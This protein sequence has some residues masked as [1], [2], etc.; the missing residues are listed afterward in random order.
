M[1]I[2]II[3][4]LMFQGVYLFS[5]S[6]RKGL[7]LS[8]SINQALN[9]NPELKIVRLQT[10]K[11]ELDILQEF[12]DIKDTDLKRKRKGKSLLELE[13]KEKDIIDTVTYNVTERYYNTIISFKELKLAEEDLKITRDY[14]Y[15]TKKNFNDGKTDESNLEEVKELYKSKEEA[16]ILKQSSYEQNKLL[17]MLSIHEPFE[18]QIYLVDNISEN[19][20]IS[21][22]TSLRTSLLV[23]NRAIRLARLNNAL[24]TLEYELV[25]ED[26]DSKNTILQAEYDMR[27]AEL[28]LN[29]EIRKQEVEMW[30]RYLKIK[31]VKANIKT[32]K[33]KM[34]R[35]KD[36]QINSQLKY[37]K[38]YINKYQLDQSYI[39]YK[40]AEMSYYKAIKNLN[41]ATL[42]LNFILR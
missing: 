29:Y 37:S 2:F 42:N 1:R 3:V 24:K 40:N 41:L 15:E 35:L 25:D 33:K 16:I 12:I 18:S 19:I 31:E 22:Y 30:T 10:R 9:K 26:V 11:T 27:E 8:Q 4:L 39:N 23:D 13:N 7:S 5:Y 38:G 20:R 6:G 14:L 17:F 28:N 21:R 32:L 36:E 34:S